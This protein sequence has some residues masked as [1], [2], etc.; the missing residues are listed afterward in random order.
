MANAKPASSWLDQRHYADLDP[1]AERALRAAGLHWHDDVE[2]ERLLREA[3]RIAPTHVAVVVAQYRYHLY[4]H[5]FQEAE[6]FARKCLSLSCDELHAPED[7]R[8]V[9]SRHADFTSSEKHV[10]FWLFALQAYGYVLL[11]CGRLAE[12]MDALHKV[13]ELDRDDQ[14]KTRVLVEVI[15]RAGRD[16]ESAA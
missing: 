8:L 1:R 15:E 7:F 2:A 10:R 3:E 13:V 14:T 4:K 5:R 6:V 16:D 11:R 9:T 12:G